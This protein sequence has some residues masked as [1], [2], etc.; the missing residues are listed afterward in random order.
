MNFAG[1]EIVIDCRDIAYTEWDVGSGLELD[2]RSWSGL[3]DGGV[4]WV[5]DGVRW[6]A[7][8]AEPA[9][10]VLHL[11]WAMPGPGRASVGFT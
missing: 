7:D 6:G 10:L 4:G 5:W 9:V 2:P 8:A 1:L 3:T 11:A